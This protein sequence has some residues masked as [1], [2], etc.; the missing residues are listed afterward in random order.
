MAKLNVI[1]RSKMSKK[2]QR[3]LN[4]AQR[5]TWGTMSPVTRTPPKSGS[6]NR[7]KEKKACR[8]ESLQAF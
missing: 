8:D 2:K 6:Y 3:E 1:S 5:R 4:A 7:G